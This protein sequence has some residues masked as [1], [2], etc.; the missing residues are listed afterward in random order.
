MGGFP[1]IFVLGIGVSMTTRAPGIYLV[2][3]VFF[4]QRTN[5]GI[6]IVAIKGAVPVFREEQVR[7]MFAGVIFW[8]VQTADWMGN[9][10]DQVGPSSLGDVDFQTDWLCFDKYYISG[11][12]GRIHYEFNLAG[13]GLW[14][15]QFSGAEVGNG[16]ANCVI[17][18]LPKGMLEPMSSP[19]HEAN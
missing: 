18:P 17:T 10:E 9:F 1:S 3:G 19:G 14:V 4:Q 16:N 6:E 15:G 5:L 8:D 13:G 7:D 11:Q 2:Q 12:G